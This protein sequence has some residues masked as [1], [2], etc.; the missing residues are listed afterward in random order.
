MKYWIC[1]FLVGFGVEVFAETGL[2]MG[3]WIEHGYTEEQRDELR[4]VIQ[5]GID[6][7]FVPGA[8]ILLV[9]KGEVIF[10]EA[11]GLA[12]LET[13][14]R[15]EIDDVFFIASVTKPFTSTMMAILADRD[16]ISLGD[17]VD[18]YLP[19]FGNLQIR[20]LGPAE[21]APTI[22]QCLSHT[23]GFPGNNAM[24]AGNFSV[25]MDGSLAETVDDLASKELWGRPG[26]LHAYTRFGYMTSARVVEVVE[27]K[28]FEEVM[29]TTLLDPI[30][31]THTTFH[32]SEEVIAGM[33]K[34]YVRTEDG[35]KLRVGGPMGRVINPGGGLYSTLDD[36]GRMLLLHRN[37]GKVD[38]RQIVSAE[39]LREQYVPQ[40]STPRTGYGLGFNTLKV[41]PDGYGFR[42]Q[43]IGGSGTF[44]WMDHKEDLLFVMLSQVPTGMMVK[45]RNRVMRKIG[46][47]FVN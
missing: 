31:A 5:A 15:V 19:E 32:P 36:V 27:G 21:S 30:G 25:Y 7:K 44:A 26:T 20:D 29:Q 9:H 3:D 40:P 23:A 10:R 4:T 16:I 8:A 35:F 42:L 39:A 28:S 14:R 41:G 11:F 45:Y 33:V 2:T 38:G 24:Q 1:A 22:R 34:P 47:I 43:H 6:E 37:Q 18:K 13:G 46:E 17:T 12:D